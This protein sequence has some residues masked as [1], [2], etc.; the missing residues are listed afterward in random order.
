MK[1]PKPLS[2]NAKTLPVH[3]DEGHPFEVECRPVD[4]SGTQP[5][6]SKVIPLPPTEAKP[7]E[8]P[9]AAADA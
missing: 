3:W 9:A 6:D 2:A 7:L 1:S 8:K 4:T 5:A